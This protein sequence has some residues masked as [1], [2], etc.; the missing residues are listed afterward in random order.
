MG[1]EIVDQE[2][3]YNNI[4]RLNIAHYAGEVSYYSKASLRDVEKKIL[5]KLKPSANL[6]DLGCGSGRFSVG[7]AQTGF[8]VVSVDIT[9]Q[10]IEVAKQRA[11][12]LGI[13]NVNF[14]CGDMTDL[15]FEN[16]VFDYVFC[17]RF[18]INAVATFPKRKKAIE[19]MLRVAKDEGVVF[20]ESFNK[21]YL[22][23]GIIFLFKNIIRDFWKHLILIYCYLTRKSY[24]KLLPGDIIYESNKVIGA[25]KG[26]AHLPTIFELIKLIPKNVKFKFYSIP[27]IIQNKKFD[28]L[29]FFRY[30]IWI[31]MT[32]KSSEKL[33]NLI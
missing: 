23:R 3:Y 15:P 14:L 25:P 8:K 27:Q 24:T 18:S 29:K 32:K 16:K 28:F 1:G 13:T 19:E 7:A 31:F 2:K 33:T 6:L 26:Y 4:K 9:P 5:I 17:P 21:F 22:G 20:I 30:S 12:R 10:A 11:K